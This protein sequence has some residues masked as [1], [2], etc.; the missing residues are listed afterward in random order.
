MTAG[1][2]GKRIASNEAAAEAVGLRPSRL[3]A[4][5]LAVIVGAFVSV[6]VPLMYRLP[7]GQ[8]EDYYAVPGSTILRDG[9]PRIPYVPSR[10]PNGVF[11]Q[12]DHV[13]FA[14]PPAYFYWQAAVYWIAGPS[15][16][17]G[18]LASALAGA[19]A[20]GLVFLLGRR[21]Y[22]NDVVGLVAAGLYSV[23]RLFYLYAAT[24]ARPDM[25][26]GAIG[27]AAILCMHHWHTSRKRRWLATA[28]ALAG[29]GLLTHP[30]AGV[31]CVL[32][33]VWTIGGAVGMS[34][35][36]PPRAII[37]RCA[38]NFTLLVLCAAGVFA[39]W[40]PLI[41]LDP[42]AF[43]MQFGNN[44][45][46]RSPGGLVARGL[47]PISGLA[48]Q[49]RLFL[50]LNGVRQTALLALG[51]IIATLIDF[52]RSRMAVVLPWSAAALLV[53]LQGEH[54]AKGYWCF[55]GALLYLCV[56][57]VIV[58]AESLARQSLG[59]QRIVPIAFAGLLGAVMLPG[60]GVRTF[61]QH[62]RHWDDPDY[63]H[64]AFVQDL[65]DR[66]PRDV[67]YLVD[68]SNVFDF[69]LA[70]RD[71]TLALNISPYFEAVGLRYDLMI[72]GPTGLRQKLPEQLDGVFLWSG[73]LADSDFA[74]YAEVYR[75]N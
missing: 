58:A 28:G 75:S 42:D 46:R 37:R 1:E 33:G 41:V 56:G 15:Y 39:L 60:S 73:G 61:V 44:V 9:I 18:R 14:L 3:C 47:S 8:D 64:S 27:L 19:A 68:V 50:E 12:A 25:L 20:I 62:L 53:L 70:G 23:S 30:F 2:A 38:E 69:Y 17:S 59:M 63:N 48:V 45:L 5:V 22:G 43:W 24:M 65:L 55:P 26:C 35:P 72:V 71:V 16:G 11:Y 34:Y 32:I 51:L 66:T 74:C 52:R 31:Y 10:D 7:G 67:K 4:A 13:L 6:R 36:G 57:R 54:P 49:A 21:I 40:L 29:L